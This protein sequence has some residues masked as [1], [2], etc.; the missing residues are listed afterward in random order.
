MLEVLKYLRD[1]GYRTYIVTGRA[2]MMLEHTQAGGGAAL[3]MLAL[4][5]DAQREY[6]YGPA[7][8]LPDT[9]VGYLHGSVG[10]RPSLAWRSLTQ[11]P[12]S[13]EVR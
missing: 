5:D 11:N 4:H 6:A 1:N 2:G 12:P 10:L 9:K 7:Q 8:G 13:K 3:E